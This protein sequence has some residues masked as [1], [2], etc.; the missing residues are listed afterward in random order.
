MESGD[1]VYVDFVGKIKDSGEIFDLTKEDIAKKENVF[2]EKIR[3]KPVPMVVDGELVIAGLNDAVKG[4]KVG[5]KKSVDI[6]PEKA[7]GERNAELI[8]LIPESRFNKQGIDSAVGA[9]VTI[10][11]LRGKIVS[12]DG[13]RVRVDF[14][15]PL[16]GK[17]LHYDLEISSQIEKD[18]EKIKALCY[19]FIGVDESDV[20]AAE[21][22][23][24]FEIK[25]KKRFDMLIEAKE[26]VA[27]IAMKWIKNI[28]KIKFVDEFENK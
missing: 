22:N 25:F 3:Y 4:M 9:F 24:I 20:E 17:T 19:Y 8:K 15:H 16:A 18:D 13:G 27:K 2:N 28:E 1:F 21:E 14:N 23:K 12:N 11:G 7:F 10:N 6:P 5:E 26:R